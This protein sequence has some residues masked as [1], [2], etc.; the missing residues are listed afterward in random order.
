MA[1]IG[2]AQIRVRP[3]LTTFRRELES[4]LARI[5]PDF[6]VKV[7]AD[8][9]PARRDIDRLIKDASRKTPTINPKVKVDTR[10]L[11]KTKKKLREIG[12]ESI[13]VTRIIARMAAS[14]IAVSV[15]AGLAASALSGT[16]T[17]AG[18]LGAALAA[19]GAAGTGVAVAG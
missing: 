7:H 5:N 10:D 17:L 19:I 2:V 15:G 12:S 11:D 6:F 13:R 9:D 4:R 16:I 3:D 1:I 8:T 14:T 18:G